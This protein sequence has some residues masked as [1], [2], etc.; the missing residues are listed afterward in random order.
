[1]SM[2]TVWMVVAVGF[3]VALAVFLLVILVKDRKERKEGRE[4]KTDYRALFVLG[5]IFIGAGI[6][7]QSILNNAGM[8]GITGLGFVYVITSLANRAQWG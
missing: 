4:A 6:A 8:F 2:D 5:M 1:M 3:I 7:L